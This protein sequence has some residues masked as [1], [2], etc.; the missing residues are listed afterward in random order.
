MEDKARTWALPYLELLAQELLAFQG[1][2][3]HFVQAFLKRFAPLDTTE[4]MR[5]ALKAFKQGKNSMAEY[6]SRFDQYTGQTGWSDADHRTR[7]Y[8][9]L[10]IGRASCRERVC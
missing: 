2:Y 3:S 1:D 7:F 8:D 10:K 4:A 9:G 5:D 6:I